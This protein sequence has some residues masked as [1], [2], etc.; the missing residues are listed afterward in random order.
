MVKKMN[1]VIYFAYIKDGSLIRIDG[2]LIRIDIADFIPL[3]EY[4]DMIID[5][6]LKDQ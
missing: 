5:K 2:S 1:N 4:R 3:D 6:S